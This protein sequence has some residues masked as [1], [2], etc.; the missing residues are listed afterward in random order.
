MKPCRSTL[1]LVTILALALGAAAFGC[2]PQR[3]FCPDVPNGACPIPMDATPE[4]DAMDAAPK[5]TGSIV[6]SDKDG[7]AD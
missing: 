1:S 6:V 7:G 5:E 2:G 4:E 3:K